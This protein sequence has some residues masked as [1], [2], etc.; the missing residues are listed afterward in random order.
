MSK[1]YLSVSSIIIISTGL[2]ESRNQQIEQ[3]KPVKKLTKEEKEALHRETESKKALIKSLKEKELNSNFEVGSYPENFDRKERATLEH[4]HFS[5]TVV[6]PWPHK[7]TST[8]K[9]KYGDETAFAHPH[10]H[11]MTMDINRVD[12]SN[13]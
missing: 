11:S 9:I 8:L 5:P 7:N 4:P 6:S 10:P 3:P 1:R 12:A 13:L 2:G